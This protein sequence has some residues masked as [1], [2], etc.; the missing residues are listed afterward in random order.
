MNKYKTIL[1]LLWFTIAFCCLFPLFYYKNRG[2]G[3]DGLFIGGETTTSK[4]KDLLKRGKFLLCWQFFW[5]KWNPVVTYETTRPLYQLCGGH[6]NPFFASIIT[7]LY[8]GIFLHGF[9]IMSPYYIY[10]VIVGKFT[11]HNLPII[12]VMIWFIL[13]LPVA[14]ANTLRLRRINKREK[15]YDAKLVYHFPQTAISA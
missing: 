7:F 14:I 5:A 9:S 2:M 12:N 10:L 1:R 6:K 4:L 11:A 15:R 13:G 3:K 8:S